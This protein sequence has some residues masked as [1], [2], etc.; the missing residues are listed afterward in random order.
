MA[1]QKK[2][3]LIYGATGYTGRL[4]CQHA[5]SIG[6]DFF[7]AGR[8][9][10]KLKAL[11]ALLQVQYCVF[12][13][14]DAYLVKAAL[15]NCQVLLNCAGPFLR[16][17]EPLI[18]ACI[19]TNVH[20]LDIAAELDSYRLSEQRDDEAR[21]VGVMLLPGCGGSVAMLGCLAAHALEAAKGK[22]PA[23]SIDVA[24]HVAGSMS[25]G[26]AVSAAENLT[27]E[28]LERRQGK[29]TAVEDT[30]PRQV[31]FA[32]GRG[33]VPCVPVTLPD[34]ITIGRA[35][36]VGNIR[37]YVN[38]SGDA[39]P[40]G[41]LH[42]LPNGPTAE[43]RDLNPYHAAAI[44]KSENGSVTMSVLHT[45]NGYT[46]TPIA[47]VEA[48]RRVLDGAWRPGFQTPVVV[49]GSGFVESIP[50]SKVLDV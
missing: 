8:S 38:V 33:A 44:V 19:N 35:T 7:I 27:T 39:F 46:F 50:G 30:S 17:A 18:S 15:R 40:T 3:F 11:A 14:D 25:P 26:S 34:L 10:A 4:A 37:T 20:Y 1:A 48:A 49:F 24:L 5:K 45:V 12:D 43:Q 6:L 32:D 16:T 41:D 21:H 23:V 2:T 47:A 36:G 29:L 31:D 28:C 42:K 22:G 9:E 13:V